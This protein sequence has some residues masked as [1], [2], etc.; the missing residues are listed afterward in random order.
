MGSAGEKEEA[1]EKC[2]LGPS[3]MILFRIKAR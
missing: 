2:E 3:V 1:V